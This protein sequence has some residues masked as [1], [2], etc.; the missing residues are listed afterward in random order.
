[1][2]IKNLLVA[3]NGSEASDAALHNAMLMQR[4]YDA[5][6]TGLLAQGDPSTMGRDLPWMPESIRN[7]IATAAAEAADQLKERFRDATAAAPA[8]H[9]HWIDS[10]GESNATVAEYGR[11]FDLTILGTHEK[12]GAKEHLELHPDRIALISGRPVLVFPAGHRA[13]KIVEHAVLAW[14]GSRAAARAMNDAMQI[15]ETKALVTVVTVGKARPEASPPGIDVETAL[16]RHGVRTEKAALKESGGS[17]AHTI[18]DHCAECGAGLLVMG[19]YEHSKFREDFLGG[20]THTVL[21][22]TQLP[23]FLSH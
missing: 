3:Y 16:A 17:I 15:L 21:R 14:D 20:V 8:D 19:A 1:M 23:V 12:M 10:R 7:S 22:E 18:L 13:E 2:A 4:K 5:H 11:L 9:I 6:V